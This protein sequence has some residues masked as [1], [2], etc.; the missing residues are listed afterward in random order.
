MAGIGLFELETPLSFLEAR[1]TKSAL[2]AAIEAMA[3]YGSDSDCLE[4]I[5][6][7]HAA[8]AKESAEAFR[9]HEREKEAAPQ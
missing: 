5:A 6:L 8:M 3:H 2:C 1:V 4:R 7:L 9:R